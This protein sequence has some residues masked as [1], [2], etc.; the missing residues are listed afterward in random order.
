MWTNPSYSLWVTS[1][2][3]FGYRPTRI[4]LEST[5]L[6]RQ[7]T[8][9]KGTSVRNRAICLSGVESKTVMP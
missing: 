7:A 1:A 5:S 6:E 4:G 8:S 3:F 2:I 9:W